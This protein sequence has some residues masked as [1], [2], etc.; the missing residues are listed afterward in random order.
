[1]DWEIG[2]TQ[3]VMKQEDMNCAKPGNT[4]YRNCDKPENR[5][6]RN[7]DETG[8]RKYTNRDKTQK[9]TTQDSPNCVFIYLY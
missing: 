9:K 6:Y 8:N 1:M 7:C 3:T 2:S 5:N 4:K